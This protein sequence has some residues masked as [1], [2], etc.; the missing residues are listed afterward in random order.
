MRD[1]KTSLHRIIKLGLVCLLFSGGAWSM[2][3]EDALAQEGAVQRQVR[4]YVPP[5]QLVSFLPSTP[6]DRFVEFVDPIFR[7]VTGKEVIDPESRDYPIGISISGLQFLDA[8]ELVLAYNSLQYRETERYFMIEAVPEQTLFKDADDATGRGGVDAGTTLAPATLDTKQ[9]KIDAVLFELNHTKARDSG[10]DWSILLGSTGSTTGGGSGGSGGSSGGSQTSQNSLRVFLNTEQFIGKNNY[11][12]TPETIDLSNLN[13]MI[14]IAES[15][16]VGETI[17][18]PNVTVQSGIEGRIQIGSDVPVQVRDFAGNAVTQF[19]STGI[20]IK[21]T[22][23]MITEPVADTLGAPTLDFIHLTVE[24]EKSSSRPSAEGPII[25]RST[26][27]TQVL[28]LDGEQTVIGGL[29]ST[30][31]TSTRT[32][33][34]LLKDLPPWF[35]GL[36]YIFGRTQEATTQKELLIVLQASVEDPLLVR[37]R[38]PVNNDILNSRRREIQKILRQFDGDV[39]RK[40]AETNAFEKSKK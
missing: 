9:I 40:V 6:F 3:A 35:F 23:V 12:K 36:R 29:Y 24:V 28:L 11:F 38:R 32:G 1:M 39:A 7:R 30:A 5:D 2:R 21:V 14:R 27:K 20:I 10:I 17:A 16:G 26:A 18:S 25:D 19:F 13:S 33:V 15:V 22:P 31:Q 8:L 37:S 4:A 34:P